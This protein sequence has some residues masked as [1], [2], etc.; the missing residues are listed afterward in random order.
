MLC[1][2]VPTT[3]C[4]YREGFSISA[5]PFHSLNILPCPP[6]TSVTTMRDPTSSNAIYL[7]IYPSPIS[8][9]ILLFQRSTIPQT[10]SL[11]IKTHSVDTSTLDTAYDVCSNSSIQ[12]LKFMSDEKE[13]LK[14]TYI[15]V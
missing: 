8:S 6:L 10:H 13:V 14:T 12:I 1:A 15:R 3:P 9:I 5:V 7:S 11:A 4:P 2:L